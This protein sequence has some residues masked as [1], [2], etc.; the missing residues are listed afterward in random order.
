MLKIILH[1]IGSVFRSRRALALEILTLRHQLYVLQRARLRV[2]LK[3]RDRLF[4]IALSRV[5]RDWREPLT[6]VQPET[7]IHWHCTGFRIFW[8]WKNLTNRQGRPRLTLDERSLIRQ[9][10][11][12]TRSGERPASTESC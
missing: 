2:R 9:V 3:K 10:A 11:S 4:W 1:L 12:N 5:W 7:V 8:R 6:I